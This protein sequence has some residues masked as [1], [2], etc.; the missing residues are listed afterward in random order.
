VS[1][2]HATRQNRDGSPCP[3]W[4]AADHDDGSFAAEAHVSHTGTIDFGD[5]GLDSIW[6]S[7]LLDRYHDDRPAVAVTGHRCRQPGWSQ[8]Q[9]PD[10]HAEALAAIVDMLAAA[11]PEQH[12]ELAAAIRRAAADI[13]EGA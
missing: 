12:R 10:I 3:P 1:G 5:S 9:V 2:D 7:A 11:T 8:V 4:C 13:T 6:V